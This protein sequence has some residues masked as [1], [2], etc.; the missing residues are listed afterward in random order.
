MHPLTRGSEPSCLATG[1]QTWT[2]DWVSALEKNSS[3]AFRWRSDDCTS[4]IRAA[5]AR[6]TE[7]HC[8]YCDTSPKLHPEID[9]FR[10]KR[11]FPEQ[12]FAWTNLYGTCHECNNL[13]RETHHEDLL[14]PDSADYD[15][16]AYFTL[17][18]AEYRLA[19][20]PAATQHDQERALK[21]IET[22]KLNRPDL[23]HARKN[24]RAREF[25]FMTQQTQSQDEA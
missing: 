19:P 2:A 15:F 23:I 17:A 10:P 21:T 4:T 12:A 8:S 9:H 25:R 24:P 18:G 1:T 20:N 16:D 22:L 7:G 5:L 14:R 13:K 3:I 6:D 11:L